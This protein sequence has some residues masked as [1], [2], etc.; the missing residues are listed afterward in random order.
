MTLILSKN[1]DIE[2]AEAI[3]QQKYPNLKVKRT[4]NKFIRVL[5]GK[6]LALVKFNKKET[7]VHGDI[8][9]NDPVNMVLLVLGVLSGAIGLL[10]FFGIEW[11]ILSKKIKG[12]KKEVFDVLEG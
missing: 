1:I 10:F 7:S 9:V 12:F 6:Y 2:S 11:I 8:N 4:K 5:N 3:L